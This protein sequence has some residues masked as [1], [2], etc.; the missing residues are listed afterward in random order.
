LHR[1]SKRYLQLGRQMFAK[2]VELD[3][4]YARAYAGIAA[5]DANL[6]M[7][8]HVE[9]PID[10]ILASAAKALAL[11][12]KLAEAHASRPVA[13]SAGERYEEAKEEFE[14][15]IALDPNSYEAHYFYARS[16]FTQGKIEQA[17][18]LFERAG[19]INP[20]DYQSPCLLVAIYKSLG[21]EEDAKS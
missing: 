4:N 18:A 17:A 11:D 13:L 2:A 6:Y 9:V 12:P 10:G 16:S 19:E 21:R 14:K 5:C 7:T 20:D 15:A 3:P 1:R 8:Y